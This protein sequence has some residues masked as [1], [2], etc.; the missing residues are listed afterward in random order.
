MFQEKIV[1]EVKNVKEDGEGVWPTIKQLQKLK[2]LDRCI[3]ES[4][5]LYPVVPLIARDI[6]QPVQICKFLKFAPKKK[7]QLFNNYIMSTKNSQFIM[8]N[9][10]CISWG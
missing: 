2:Y 6:K 4:L 1:Q 8:Y 9:T 3:K 7:K 10:L 5:R